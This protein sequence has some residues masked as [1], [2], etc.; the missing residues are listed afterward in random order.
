MVEICKSYRSPYTYLFDYQGIKIKIIFFRSIHPFIRG[1]LQIGKECVI[2][3]EIKFFQQ[4]WQISHPNFIFS[5]EDINLV[6]PIYHLTKGLTNKSLHQFI[7]QSIKIT[8]NSIKKSKEFNPLAVRNKWPSFIDSI[9][10]IHIPNNTIS[11][12]REAFIRLASDELIA[13]QIQLNSNK[14]IKLKKNVFKENLTLK[15]KVL[16]KLKFDLTDNQK[17]V[18]KE[19]E[20]AQQ[21]NKQMTMLLQGDVGSGKTII[22]IMSMLNVIHKFD[23]QI[24]FMCPTELLAKQHYEYIK[25]L[26]ESVNLKCV[27]LSNSLTRKEKIITL[28]KIKDG[29]TNIIVGTHSLFQEKVTFKNLS[30]II[31]DEQHKF[32]VQQRIDLINKT[33]NGNFCDVLLISATP[34]PRSLLL[35]TLGKVTVFQLKNTI[36]ERKEIKTY[37]KKIVKEDEV[38]HF[39]NVILQKGQ[40]IY[41]IC[42]LID[43]ENDKN[44]DQ[45]VSSVENRLNKL[46]KYFPSELICTM[47]SKLNLEERDKRMKD[48]KNG[49]YR[50]LIATT[51][52]ELGIDIVNT[53]LIVIEN[54]ERFGL[55]QL[56]QLRGRVGRNNLQSYCILLYGEKISKMAKKRLQIL[57]E[58]T[59]GFKIA[60]K[61]LEIRGGGEL[62]GKKQSGKEDFIFLNKIQYNKELLEEVIKAAQSLKDAKHSKEFFSLFLFDKSLSNF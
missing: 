19:I 62:F 59:D 14:N 23:S 52:I 29:L 27:L 50:I 38:Y 2:E 8:E 41:W 43:V 42:P 30:Y 15:N 46:K 31:I 11:N 9:K 37:L 5:K 25:D 16:S 48:F 32:G 4:S 33:N 6:E 3:G 10:I 49:K 20:K 18:L 24:A 61:D 44:N 12:I 26:V 39:I 47:H 51:I 13:H 17:Y 7:I 1:L 56:H 60:Q 40:Q 21:N 22:A 57:K 34:I 45:E 55:A 54:A 53:T 58:S 35:A 28:K 36:S